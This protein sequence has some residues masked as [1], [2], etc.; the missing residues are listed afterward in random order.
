M[1]SFKLLLERTH[2][3]VGTICYM[4]FLNLG[5]YENDCILVRKKEDKFF[6]VSPTQQRTR[7]QEWMENHL[8]TDNSI[9]FQDVTSEYAVLTVVGPKSKDLM[10]E[11][12]N[13]DMSMQPFTFKY[14]NIGY[15][16]GVMAFTVTQT[17]EPGY[18]LYVRCDNALQVYLQIM[19][20][21]ADYNIKNV[22]HL[23]MR[24]LR[25]EK[26]I[27]FWGEE[28]TSETTPIEVG[29]MSKVKFDKPSFIGKEKLLEQR[30][31]GVL[32]RLV[33]I[34]LKVFDKETDPWPWTG[35]AIYRNGEYVG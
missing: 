9:D 35:E 19:K 21:G 25:L 31:T 10:Q 14:V 30:A 23:A 4:V 6:M 13:S 24:F 12:T 3:A 34:Q 27:P 29:R 26:F 18:S 16:S 2:D 32:K 28:L 8:P 1:S 5:G 17:G 33:Q 7:I 20:I 11:M 22:G 15:A